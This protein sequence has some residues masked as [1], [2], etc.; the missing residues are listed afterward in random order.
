MIVCFFYIINEVKEEIEGSVDMDE[1]IK[2]S[3]CALLICQRKVLILKRSPLDDFLPNV[4]E[5][6]GG[7][8]EKGETLHEA[9][10]REIKEETHLDISGISAKL[11]GISEEISS[12]KH[13]VQVNYEIILSGSVQITLSLEHMAYDWIERCDERIDDFLKNILKQSSHCQNWV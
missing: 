5:F 1:K 3:V 6:P 11:I 9:L 4:W 10:I 2:L 13:D 8:L 12:E 7:S